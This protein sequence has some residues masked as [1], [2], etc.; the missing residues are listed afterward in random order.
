MGR[1]DDGCQGP[2]IVSP[3]GKEPMLRF[4]LDAGGRI[5]RREP[6]EVPVTGAM[7]LLC[8]FDALYVNGAGPRWIS[9]VSRDGLERR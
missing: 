7:G 3:Q 6:I 2:L 4:T 8:A 5:A 1:D 9:S